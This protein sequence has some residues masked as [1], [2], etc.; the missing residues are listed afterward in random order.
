M[1]P[2]K[3]IA[4]GVQAVQIVVTELPIEDALG[5]ARTRFQQ[6]D[7]RLSRALAGSASGLPWV[8]LG[9]LALAVGAPALAGVLPLAGDAALAAGV[10]SLVLGGASL[11]Y[12]L[13]N[14]SRARSEKKR[15]TREWQHAL[16]M[17]R[18]REQQAEESPGM[19]VEVLDRVDDHHHA[20]LVSKWNRLTAG[21]SKYVQ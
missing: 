17:L 18:L 9:V 12:G 4:I 19:S 10:I 7:E 21:A 15:R 5:R 6:A 16:E 2:S 8:V 13:P 3:N 11:G 1:A 20:A 14:W